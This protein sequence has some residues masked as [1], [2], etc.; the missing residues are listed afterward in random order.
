[1]DAYGTG[2]RPRCAASA[3]TALEA[4]AYDDIRQGDAPSS[5]GQL[6]SGPAPS[7]QS[8]SCRGQS[9][10]RANAIQSTWGWEAGLQ[11][12]EKDLQQLKRQNSKTPA[13]TTFSVT[14]NEIRQQ[15]TV[16]QTTRKEAASRASVA[17]L[18]TRTPA[19]QKK[20][21]DSWPA[22][23]MLHSVTDTREEAEGT[24]DP[25]TCG[26]NC[27]AYWTTEAFCH[28]VRSPF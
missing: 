12:A 23:K 11:E 6:R 16:S 8:T 10:K 4:L 13:N 1:M 17:K 3:L 28:E 27:G 24:V 22:S 5:D 9:Q 18:A 15:K 2:D 26:K 25:S 14:E 19:T 21:R 7:D 20:H